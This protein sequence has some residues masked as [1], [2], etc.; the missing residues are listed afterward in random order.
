MVIEH[1]QHLD[2]VQSTLDVSRLVPRR[3][4]SR[5]L[6]SICEKGSESQLHCKGLRCP[7]KCC[8]CINSLL[9]YPSL[10]PRVL[11][12]TW[13][14][15]SQPYDFL[16]F[17]IQMKGMRSFWRGAVLWLRWG[18]VFFPIFLIIEKGGDVY[19]IYIYIYTYK[20]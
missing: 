15:S 7:M 9:L 14:S 6:F 3:R 16:R 20:S 8:V 1:D 13:M 5:C 12:I 11:Y 10:W 17:K 2:S 4:S 19:N 18:D